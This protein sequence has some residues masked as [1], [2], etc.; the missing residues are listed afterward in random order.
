MAVGA[1]EPGTRAITHRV[2]RARMEFLERGR[3]CNVGEAGSLPHF[4]PEPYHQEV[5]RRDRDPAPSRPT[6][7]GPSYLTQ[8]TR[9]SGFGRHGEG[10]RTSFTVARGHLTGSPI[11]RSSFGR[12]A[13]SVC[14]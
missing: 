10:L 13:S 8:S 7:Q 14:R 12:D 3:Q 6:R 4:L 2:T 1:T 5:S 9:A 11:S